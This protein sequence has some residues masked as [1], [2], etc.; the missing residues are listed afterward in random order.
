M[1]QYLVRSHICACQTLIV[2][3]KVKQSTNKKQTRKCFVQ[4]T[5]SCCSLFFIASQM[6]SFSIAVPLPQRLS[7]KLTISLLLK[8]TIDLLFFRNIYS[9]DS[10]KVSCGKF[11][12]QKATAN[13]CG[14]FPRQI[15]TA[16][17]H[18]EYAPHISRANNHC[19]YMRRCAKKFHVLTYVK[20]MCLSFIYKGNDNLMIVLL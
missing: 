17:S 4:F 11:P 1:N 9:M 10:R 3:Y 5:Q 8:N 20:Q 13:S 18:G 2:Q 6:A 19:K 16:N 12:R 15:A 14:K 7:M